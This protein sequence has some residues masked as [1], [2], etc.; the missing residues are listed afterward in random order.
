MDKKIIKSKSGV[1]IK[2]PVNT[3]IVKIILK[4]TVDLDVYY[5]N[6]SNIEQ[7]K[8]TGSFLD[9]NG[10]IYKKTGNN[11]EDVINAL[12]GESFFVIINDATNDAELS[13]EI[14]SANFGTAGTS[15][16]SG[17]SS[18]C[19]TPVMTGFGTSGYGR[20]GYK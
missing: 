7:L 18:T 1:I 6:K 13:F 17:T 5:A 15:G 4:S 12:S 16:I 8:K 3:G 2:C 9:D 11:I 20:S 10:V 14:K 19:A